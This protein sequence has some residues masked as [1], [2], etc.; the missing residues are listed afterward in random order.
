MECGVLPHG[1]GHDQDV[2]SF[3]CRRH[4]GSHA[5]G[6]SRTSTNATQDNIH[7]D[8]FDGQ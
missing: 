2:D 1:V 6:A 8:E 5:A 7:T 4:V 3:R